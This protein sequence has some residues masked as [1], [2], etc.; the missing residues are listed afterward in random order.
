MPTEID[1]RGTHMHEMVN[2]KCVKCG[3]TREELMP[4]QSHNEKEFGV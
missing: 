2:N 4:V 1:F 3:K